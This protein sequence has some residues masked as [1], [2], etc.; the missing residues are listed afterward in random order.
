MKFINKLTRVALFT[1]I[2]LTF[3]SLTFGTSLR[4]AYALWDI[5]VYQES[6][7]NSGWENWSWGSTVRF[8]KYW[9]VYG[10]KT[11]IQVTSNAWGALYLHSKNSID[12]DDYDRLQFQLY[13]KISN[14][15]LKVLIYD[16]NNKKVAELNLS[17]FGGYPSKDKWKE[18]NIPFS[19]ISNVSSI[20]GF[21]IQNAT[22]NT[23]ESIYLDNVYIKTSSEGD[24]KTSET[25]PSQPSE[26]TKPSDPDQQKP[27]EPKDT[28]QPSA[29][30]SKGGYSTANGKVYK[31]GSPLKIKGV[32]WFGFDGGTKVVHG[33]WARNWKDMISQ[34]KSLGFNSV[35]VPYCPKVL[36]GESVSSI[37][38]SLNPD[39][40]GLNSLQ[41]FDKVLNELN[42]QGLHILVDVHT[43]DCVAI[44]DLWYTSS[45]SESEWINDLKFV[46][47]RYKGLSNFLGIDMKNE[48]K[49]KATWGTG[50]AK[51]DWKMAAEK[52]GKAILEVNPNILIFVE[53]VQNN[54]NC[55]GNTAHWWGGNMEPMAC[56]PI[57]N[58]YIPAN[59]LVYSP[60]VYGPDVHMQSYF[61]AS[62]FPGNMPSI[63][64]THFG[65][66][67]DK[68]YTVIPTEWGGR[69]G[70]G[71]DAK[72]VTWHNALINYFK[73]K[74]ICSTYYWDWN[75][76]SGDT[77]GILK[78][79]WKT[80]WANKVKMLT[81][82]YNSCSL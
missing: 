53:G 13:S 6:K 78:D 56:K 49:G 63:W 60:H 33:L 20:K 81:D 43:P 75:P 16:S 28:T 37:N 18:Y 29:E 54:P 50:D 65:F 68:G 47:N 11:S 62:T 14:Q 72:D 2:A 57:N 70:N 82:F 15:K 58:N 23:T 36:D 61:T 48:P 35:R 30:P 22:G 77:G 7:L 39:L 26:P 5:T 71:G 59:K 51:T 12:L 27:E 32:N 52:A 73:S 45:Y 8:D 34:I 41:I 55:S 80:P 46:A 31:N 66:L 79:D 38:Y 24:D 4:K 42:N 40:K 17:D 19:K 64:T 67:A 25:T 10:G 74:K 76:N 9:P 21:A 3:V 44:S 69:Y 1:L